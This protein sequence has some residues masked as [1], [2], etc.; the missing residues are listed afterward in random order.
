M[1]IPLVWIVVFVAHA[2]V[3]VVVVGAGAVFGELEMRDCLA[4][5]VL[6]DSCSS[7]CRW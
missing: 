1:S 4:I 6:G 5:Y 2:V 3:V 7:W